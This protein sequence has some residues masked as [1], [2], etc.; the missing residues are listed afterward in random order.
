MFTFSNKIGAGGRKF[1]FDF[2]SSKQEINL[3]RLGCLLKLPP[4][5]HQSAKVIRV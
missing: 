3:T 4:Y 5:V 2:A 1:L